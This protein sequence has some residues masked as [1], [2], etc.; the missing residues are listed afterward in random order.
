MTRRLALAGL[1]ALAAVVLYE[2]VTFGQVWLTSRR[3]EARPAQ[4]I[5]VLGAAQYNGRPSAV[6][7]ARLDHAADLWHR[8]LAPTVVVTGGRRS[9]DPFTEASSSAAYL[10]SKGVPDA[11]VLREVSGRSSWQSLAAAARFLRTR[12]IG[13]VILVSD[14]FHAARI[15]A[16][17]HELGLHGRSSPTRTSPIRGWSALREMLRETLAISVGRLI[18]FRRLARVRTVSG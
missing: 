9:G 8:R 6:L 13:N 7:R 14:P 5:V 17:S 3:D 1:L 10:A 16:M 2:A 12:G 4:A 18:G 11:S 15:K